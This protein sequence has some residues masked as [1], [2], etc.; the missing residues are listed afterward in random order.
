VCLL[1][2]N[3]RAFQPLTRRAKVAQHTRKRVSI[4][5]PTRD[6]APIERLDTSDPSAWRV[7]PVPGGSTRPAYGSITGSHVLVMKEIIRRWM[8]LRVGLGNVRLGRVP[9]GEDVITAAHLVTLLV[10]Q[11][12]RVVQSLFRLLLEL[13]ERAL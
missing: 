10:R 9:V 11:F 8:H 3:L 12:D 2:A 7:E 4:Q 13:G 1:Y 6:R 5:C